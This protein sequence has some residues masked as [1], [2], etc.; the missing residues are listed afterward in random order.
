MRRCPAPAFADAANGG[1]FF[2]FTN[3]LT[4]VLMISPDKALMQIKKPPGGGFFWP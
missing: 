1:Y 2:H 4:W 3:D